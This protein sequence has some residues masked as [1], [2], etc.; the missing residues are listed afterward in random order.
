MFSSKQKTQTEIK[1]PKD[2][3]MFSLYSFFYTVAFVLISPLFLLRRKKYASGFKQRLGFL[4]K[5]K[6]ST[7]PIIWIHCVSVGETNAARPLINKILKKY[8]NYRLVVSTTTKTGQDLAQKLF[9][10][11]ADMVFYFPFDW[12]FTVQRVLRQIRP[13]VVLIMETEIWFNFIREATKN[14][15]QVFIVNGRLS[16]KSAK[17]YLWVK[18]SMRRVLRSIEAALMQTPEDAKRIINLGIRA[19]KVKVT[20]NFKFDQNP[21]ESEQNL[22]AYFKER[23]G[24]SNGRPLILAASTH[25]DEEKWVLEAFKKIRELKLSNSPRL[26]LVPRHPE[27]FS[28]VEGLIKKT[29]FSWVKRT[30]PLGLDDES[31]DIIL[32]DSIGELLSIYPLAEVVFVGGSLIPHG[33]QNILEPAYAKKAIVTGSYMMNFEAMAKEF[34]RHG[35]FI[36]IPKLKEKQ[37]PDKLAEV[38]SELLVKE[39]LRNH[40]AANAFTVL[41]KNRGATDKTLKYLS[42]YLQ[43]QNFMSD[44]KKRVP[45]ENKKEENVKTL[46]ARR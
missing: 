22:T 2:L 11:D 10:D 20:G 45:E 30:S 33:G 32:L 37:I 9:A 34:A 17:R 16:E 39:K 41:K 19:S 18:R 14:H 35:A 44:Q 13:N 12:K 28:E 3:S 29:E 31:A 40:L 24:L 38:F 26:M 23:F 1:S 4:P 36:Q 42:S 7:R 8:P 43:V 25:A 15:A 27:R 46:A 21:T 5:F 6:K